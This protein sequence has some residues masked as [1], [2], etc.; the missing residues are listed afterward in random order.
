MYYLLNYSEK[1]EP[2]LCCLGLYLSL[3][4]VGILIQ[5]SNVGTGLAPVRERVQVCYLPIFCACQGGSDRAYE[6]PL[7]NANRYE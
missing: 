6:I 1:S 7:L 2:G 5:S 3:A 4:Y